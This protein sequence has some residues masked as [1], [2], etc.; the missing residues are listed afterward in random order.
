MGLLRFFRQFY[1]SLA[2]AIGALRENLLR[3]TLS[4]LGVTIGIFSIISV[5]TAVD[6]LES[7]VQGALN[8]V[9]DDVIFIEKWPWTFGDDYPWWKYLN[10]PQANY[11]EFKFLE[12]QMTEAKS[13]CIFASAGGATFRQGSNSFTGNLAGCTYNYRD[14]SNIA[15]GEGRYFT[16]SES[17]KGYPVAIIGKE[18]EETLFP[19]RSAIGKTFSFRGKKIKVIGVLKKEGES[20]FQIFNQDQVCYTTYNCFLTFFNVDDNRGSTI[21]VASKKEDI[22]MVKLEAEAQTLM[23]ARRGLKPLQENNFALN[24]PEMFGKFIGNIFGVLKIAGTIIGLFA[25]L[26][27]GFGI[28]NIMFVSVRDRTNIIGIQKSLGA[29]NYVILTQFLFEAIFLCLLGGAVG[30][31]L[32]WALTIAATEF[33]W[34][35]GLNFTLSQGN[36]IVA[37]FISTLI[38]VV[39]G[40]VPALVAARMDPV[41]AIRSK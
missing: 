19:G 32:V 4:L 41:E 9:K 28:A 5:Y 21:A 22:G 3:T 8:F 17:E 34:V 14:A 18:I 40:L 38:G 6:A 26:V 23:R 1:E 13:V 2:F 7:S 27:G 29:K 24:R 33:K 12:D 31:F 30:L 35:S 11:K 36:V 20:L 39:A 10:R 16:P 15:V 37:L 25:L